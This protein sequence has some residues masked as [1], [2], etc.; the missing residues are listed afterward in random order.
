MR[1][2]GKQIQDVV[3]NAQA[4]GTQTWLAWIFKNPFLW[5]PLW[6]FFVLKSL[7]RLLL[8]LC[9]TIQ[10]PSNCH[11]WISVYKVFIWDSS[12]Q[13]NSLALKCHQGGNE[14]DSHIPPA[15]KTV[16][17]HWHQDK[18]QTPLSSDRA[19]RNV[20]AGKLGHR[21]VSSP[22]NLVPTKAWL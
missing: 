19:R 16:V 5:S 21:N 9:I 7:P 10:I 6:V 2:V 14:F 17:P 3:N 20:A 11:D 22:L 13:N 15:T 4:Y 1:G 18:L 12:A 8:S